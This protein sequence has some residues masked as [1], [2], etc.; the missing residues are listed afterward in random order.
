MRRKTGSARSQFR[1][2]A[3]TLAL[4]LI[5]IFTSGY[6]RNTGAAEDFGPREANRR[7]YDRAG[8]LTTGEA[9]DLEARALAAERAGAPTIVY[10][11]AKKAD[12]DDTRGDAR[13]LMDAWEVQSAPGARDGVVIFLNLKPDDLRHG[14]ASIWAGARHTG[15]GGSLP[16]GELR[17]IYEEAMRPALR[18]GETAAGIGAGLDALASSL[19]VGPPP[20]P[21]PGPVRRFAGTIAGLPLNLVAV[22]TSL[23]LALF[24]GRTWRDRPRALASGPP[25]LQRPGTLPPA[26]VGALVARRIDAAALTEATILDLARRGALTVEPDGDKQVRLHLR[27]APGGGLAFERA[28]W[29]ALSALAD[30]EGR[31]PAARLRDLS[32][33]HQALGA[34][35]RAELEGRGWF[36]PA[37][38][39][40]RKPLYLA[41]T[42]ALFAAVLAIVPSALG[43]QPWGFLAIGLFATVGLIVVILAAYLPATTASGEESAAPWHGYKA[44]IRAA[45][46]DR[47]RAIDLDALLPDAVAFG[48]SSVLDRRLKE[49]SREGY[50]PSWFVRQPGTSDGMVGFYPYWVVLHAGISPSS[51]S[52]SGGGASTGGAGA[53]G[54]F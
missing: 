33:Q 40:R 1:I 11:R 48:A 32:K 24:A 46:R 31:I 16:E 7:V 47:E 15:D 5:A 41:G 12:Q 8:L 20:P 21:A 39:A 50:A 45:D 53:G 38:D 2:V 25:T 17:R 28:L 44:G 4:A 6:T 23:A 26:I 30:A 3:L 34:A 13:A 27:D 43:Q 54:S 9:R 35:V 14:E 18:D 52:S 22:L 29:T 51:T 36:D 37:I 49:A 19:T 10:L 42:F